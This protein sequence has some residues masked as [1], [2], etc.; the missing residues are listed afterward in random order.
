MY[1]RLGAAYLCTNYL[2]LH[3]QNV[4]EL[5]SVIGLLGAHAFHAKTGMMGNP[6]G[7]IRL[8]LLLSVW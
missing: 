7:P 1:I 3:V 5:A 4:R 2:L 8:C 6:L